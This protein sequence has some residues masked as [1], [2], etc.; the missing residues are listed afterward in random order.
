MPYKLFL[1]MLAT[2]G[3]TACSAIPAPPI[4]L[5]AQGA[6]ALAGVNA[7]LTQTRVARP[8]ALRGTPLPPPTTPPAVLFQGTQYPGGSATQAPPAATMSPATALTPLPV[9]G[10]T[11]LPSPLPVTGVT[12][13]AV[14]GLAATPDCSHV[15]NVA[16]AGSKVRVAIRND[17][18]GAVSFVIGLNRPNTFGQ[19]GYIAWP[20]VPRSSKIVVEAPQSRPDLGDACY[21]AYALI[22]RPN[23]QTTITGTGFCLR[24]SQR[25]GFDIS[26]TQISLSAR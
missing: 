10:A 14:P 23:A 24:P 1:I 15:M 6:T 20:P 5:T 17:S 12:A 4:D 21:W 11:P 9:T 3:L 18:K 26:D 7:M 8:R 16:A 2:T 22:D 25:W 13:T 19:C